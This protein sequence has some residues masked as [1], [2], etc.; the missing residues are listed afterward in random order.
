MPS[1][2]ISSTSSSDEDHIS[3]DSLSSGSV[4]TTS[5]ARSDDSSIDLS[6]LNISHSSSSPV[7][8]TPITPTRDPWRISPH[9]LRYTSCPCT[10]LKLK[11]FQTMVTSEDYLRFNMDRFDK[12]L[13][14]LCKMSNI[15]RIAQNVELVLRGL[16]ERGYEL[17]HF[18]GRT[19][20]QEEGGNGRSGM[21]VFLMIPDPNN[22]LLG[23]KILAEILIHSRIMGKGKD[24]YEIA[25]RFHEDY[26]DWILIQPYEYLSDTRSRKIEYVIP[27]KKENKSWETII[28]DL[29]SKI[30]H[31]YSGLTVYAGGIIPVITRTT[32][33]LKEDGCRVY[34]FEMELVYRKTST[35]RFIKMIRIGLK[36]FPSQMNKSNSVSLSKAKKEE[37]IGAVILLEIRDDKIKNM[38][39]MYKD[40]WPVVHSYRDVIPPPDLSGLERLVES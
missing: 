10:S 11:K 2:V 3:N 12:L 32:K 35:N 29:L 33:E 28:N 20:N 14:R 19:L 24:Q 18:V 9:R 23:H 13:T 38:L 16:R 36:V 1:S 34:A 15:P 37:E 26:A 39:V 7:P 21:S 30:R 31:V 4:S 5:S 8:N 6:K 22:K 27:D 17:F 25:S 40:D